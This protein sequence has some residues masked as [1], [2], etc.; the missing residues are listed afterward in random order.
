MNIRAVIRWVCLSS[1]HVCL[2]LCNMYT[3]THIHDTRQHARMAD[4]F[5][6]ELDDL[7]QQWRHVSTQWVATSRNSHHLFAL[8]RAVLQ[9]DWDEA[10]GGQIYEQVMYVYPLVLFV[11]GYELS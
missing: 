5:R 10:D 3:C 1:S 9:A 4:S 6:A 8:V 2:C 11:Y 7:G